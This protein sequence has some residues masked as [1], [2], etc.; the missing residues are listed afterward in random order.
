MPKFEAVK[1]DELKKTIGISPQRM[2]KL[3]EYSEFLSKLTPHNG[4]KVTCDRGENI[5]TVRNNIKKAAQI[6]GKNVTTRRSGNV[7]GVYLAGK[8]RRSSKKVKKS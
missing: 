4:C 8:K 5:N 3:K 2:K 6:A 7:I 1:M